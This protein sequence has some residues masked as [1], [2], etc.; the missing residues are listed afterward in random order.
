MISNSKPSRKLI[1]IS[2]AIIEIGR[3]IFLLYSI[4]LMREFTQ[5]NGQGKDLALAT[6]DIVTNF[7][8]AIIAGLLGYFVIEYFR[9]RN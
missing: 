2:R 9:K 3:I 7:E 1:T 5:T 4:L 6:E 8:I